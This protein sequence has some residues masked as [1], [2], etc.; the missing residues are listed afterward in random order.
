MPATIDVC[1]RAL[2]NR[3]GCKQPLLDQPGMPALLCRV[4]DKLQSANLSVQTTLVARRFVFVHQT[5]SGHG[6]EHWNRSGVSIRRSSFI[7]GINCRH[8]SLNMGTHH[9]A[10]T[11]VAGTSG[12][13]LTSTFFRL[14]GIR[15]VSLLE[16]LKIQ[17]NSIVRALTVVNQSGRNQNWKKTCLRALPI[18]SGCPEHGGASS[19]GYFSVHDSSTLR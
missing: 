15:Q 18:T 8:N 16:K 1:S 4:R 19:I 6:I 3:P 14:G 13:R 7:A 5:F 10:H 9:R 11:G 12:F 17:P 2:L